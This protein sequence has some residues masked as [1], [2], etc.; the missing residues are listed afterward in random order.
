[1]GKWHLIQNQ[2]RLRE[3]FKEPPFSLLPTFSSRFL[4]PP[5]YAPPPSSKMSKS[6]MISLQCFGSLPK[7]L[8]VLRRFVIVKTV[9]ID[10]SYNLLIRHYNFLL[11]STKIWKLPLLLYRLPFFLI[12]LV[13]IVL[14]PPLSY[15][16]CSCVSLV[17]TGVDIEIFPV[18]MINI[19]WT[20]LLDAGINYKK[21]EEY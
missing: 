8:P 7:L 17:Q 10:G 1:M 13:F 16:S 6:L 5:Y 3:I 21:K 4:P 15:G 9:R 19:E 14:L 18:L 11:F 20:T 12:I 2:Q